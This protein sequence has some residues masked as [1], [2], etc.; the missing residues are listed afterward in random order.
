MRESNGSSPRSIVMRFRGCR[1]CG[2]TSSTT[3]PTTTTCW[4]RAADPDDPLRTRHVTGIVDF[5]DLVSRMW[6][7]RRHCGSLCNVAQPDP[8]QAAMHVVRG[9]HA[10]HPLTEGE[11]AALYLAR[12]SSPVHQRGAQRPSTRPGAGQ[13][14]LVDQRDGC[15]E[16]LEDSKGS[17]PSWCSTSYA[18]PSVWCRVHAVRACAAGSPPTQTVV[19]PVLEPDPRVVGAR[20]ARFERR[21]WRVERARGTR[22]CHSLEC[23]DRGAHA[24]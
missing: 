19:G 24:R 21:E 17:I 13:C 15:L 10:A 20:D 2:P 18:T 22:R 4:C 5:G 7:A 1:R 6:S 9:Y 8:V 12:V 23:R 16:L 14:V 3:T 11:L